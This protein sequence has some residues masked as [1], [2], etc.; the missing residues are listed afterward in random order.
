MSGEEVSQVESVTV[1]AQLFRSHPEESIVERV[2][3]YKMQDGALNVLP[4][5]HMSLL[6]SVHSMLEATPPPLDKYFV[7]FSHGTRQRIGMNLADAEIYIT[8]AMLFRV[9]GSPDVRMKG[10]RGY[11]EL[12]E[13]EWARDVEIVGDGVTPLNRKRS[14]WIRIKVK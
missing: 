8:L 14:R 11:L 13:T 3:V 4:E 5:T 1:V 12:F 10:D 6:R 7:P 9:Y 2:K